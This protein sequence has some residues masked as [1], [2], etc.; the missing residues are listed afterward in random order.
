MAEP[1]ARRTHVAALRLGERQQ[2]LYRSRV[3]QNAGFR[4]SPAF[5]RTRLRVSYF[6]PLALLGFLGRVSANDFAH[7]GSRGGSTGAY[8]PSAVRDMMQQLAERRQ[9]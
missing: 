6:L 7:Q 4:P 9:R 5:W 8:P 3:R 2:I 1:I